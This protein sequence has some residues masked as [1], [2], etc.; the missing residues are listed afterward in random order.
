MILQHLTHSNLIL[1]WTSSFWLP[2]DEELRHR[3]FKSCCPMRPGALT[4]A[5]H[6]PFAAHGTQEK[7]GMK[8]WVC[9]IGGRSV[10]G[11][12]RWK[13]CFILP[14]GRERVQG[15]MEQKNWHSSKACIYNYIYIYMFL[16][17]CLKAFVATEKTEIHLCWT[18][19]SVEKKLSAI[20]WPDQAPRNPLATLSESFA[21]Q[22]FEAL[23]Q[24]CGTRWGRSMVVLW[25]AWSFWNFS[26]LTRIIKWNP[27]WGDETIQIY[28]KFEGF[29]R[30]IVHCLGW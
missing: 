14:I 11:K 30:K 26:S 21:R 24:R 27:F 7:E 29:L 22:R 28:G 8:T 2:R 9:R 25:F 17:Q 4:A 19:F 15:T 6:R 5:G 23:P 18:E 1:A 10:Q 13:T 3:L 12:G 16:N 20:D